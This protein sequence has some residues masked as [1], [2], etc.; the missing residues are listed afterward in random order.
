[1]ETLTF[2]QYKLFH[3]LY[4]APILTQS[5]LTPSSPVRKPS[6]LLTTPGKELYV[7]P[8]FSLPRPPFQIFLMYSVG[9]WPCAEGGYK[10]PHS[11]IR[12]ESLH[13]APPSPTTSP[14]PTLSARF[15]SQAG[16]DAPPGT[17]VHKM[18]KCYHLAYES[19][20]EEDTKTWQVE[21]RQH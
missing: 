2:H 3:P 18:R 16:M 20:G 19:I 15:S 21:L 6:L 8:A 12:V 17:R 9:L 1:M 7:L 11:C 4:P 14:M 13:I 10:L 5:R